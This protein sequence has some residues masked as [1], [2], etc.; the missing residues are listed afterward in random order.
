[1]RVSD[2]AVTCK[3]VG[4]VE[5]T[6]WFKRETVLLPWL[7][8]KRAPRISRSAPGWT[9]GML[10]MR[11]ADWPTIQNTAAA[12]RA[13]MRMG[14]EKRRRKGSTGMPI[15]KNVKVEGT[16]TNQKGLNHYTISNIDSM[17]V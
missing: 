1:M 14:K 8:P 17:Q 10:V 12:S 11:G 15:I 9:A 6:G 2:Q 16:G 5:S 4:W 13:M 3:G 7:L